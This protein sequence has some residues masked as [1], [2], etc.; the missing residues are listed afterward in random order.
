[1]GKPE[2]RPQAYGKTYYRV[3]G[4]RAIDGQDGRAKADKYAGFVLVHRDMVEGAFGRGSPAC[5][6]SADSD[7]EKII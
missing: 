6:E 5:A 4:S 1:M 3:V 2:D 7:A